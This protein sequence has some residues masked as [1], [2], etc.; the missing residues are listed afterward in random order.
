MRGYSI[1]HCVRILRYSLDQSHRPASGRKSRMGG[2]TRGRTR[3][4]KRSIDRITRKDYRQSQGEGMD[5]GNDS[6]GRHESQDVLR[7]GY[8]L[9]MIP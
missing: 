6:C 7:S 4:T 5:R 2:I 9:Y 1:W 3:G 8:S